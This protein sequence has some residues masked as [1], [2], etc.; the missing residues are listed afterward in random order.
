LFLR[1]GITTLALKLL[2]KDP[3][4]RH[5]LIS[6]NRPGPT[7]SILCL[8]KKGGIISWEQIVGFRW[9]TI[10]WVQI[11]WLQLR[12]DGRTCIVYTEF[13][14]WD[15]KVVI[16]STIFFPKMSLWVIS[17]RPL[18]LSGTSCTSFSRFHKK[19]AI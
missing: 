8:W 18:P 12:P 15:L 5:L 4:D 10:S 7:L 9:P 19:S 14:N 1:H 16:L 13:D 17:L 2:G 6:N 11:N 3:V